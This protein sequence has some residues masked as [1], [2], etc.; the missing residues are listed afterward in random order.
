[1]GFAN[2]VA[3]IHARGIRI[4]ASFLVGY[5]DDTPDG[6]SSS[7]LSSPMHRRFML[8][9]LQSSCSV[10]RHTVCMAEMQ[11]QKRLK[12]DQWWLA[13]EYRLGDTVYEPKHF[14]ADRS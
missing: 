13:P 5:D 12:Y 8:A 4:C 14:S 1:M 9:F 6:F 10:A 7:T 11:A 3:R 2:A